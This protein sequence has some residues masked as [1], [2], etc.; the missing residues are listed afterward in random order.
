MP[1]MTTREAIQSRPGM[2]VAAT[3]EDGPA[4]A[5]HFVYE[6]LANGVD[7]FLAGTATS[8]SLEIDGSSIT[9]ED[10]GPG[11]PF[12][13]PS[14]NNDDRNLAEFYLEELHFEASADGHAPHVHVKWHGHGLVIMNALAAT[15]TVRSDDGATLWRKA[16]RDGLSEGPARLETS[17]GKT[18]TRITLQL[19]PGYEAPDLPTIRD[20]MIDQV[21]LYPGLHLSLNG[22]AF[23]ASQGLLGLAL[24][25][26]TEDSATSRKLW[27][28]A[29]SKPSAST[30]P[31]WTAMTR[32]KR[33]AGST[34]SKRHA[35][36]PMS[37]A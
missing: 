17:S 27:H 33:A 11:L 7:Q 1:I 21:H 23:L 35:A 8:L 19:A 31:C 13:L 4:V 34:V 18:G 15:L 30:W 14:P 22:E 29:N 37:K 2:Y 32:P 9:L 5:N 26:S 12:A 10:D 6:L 24:K 20:A 28:Q 3:K 16:Y 36:G 25:A